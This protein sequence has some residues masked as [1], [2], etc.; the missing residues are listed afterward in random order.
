MAMAMALLI[1]TDDLV[2]KY[3]EVTGRDS[4]NRPSSLIPFK[5]N[6]SSN[7]RYFGSED[8][9]SMPVMFSTKDQDEADTEMDFLNKQGWKVL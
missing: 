7:L 8:F 1:L 4:N 2:E 5:K 6:E 3:Y 9:P